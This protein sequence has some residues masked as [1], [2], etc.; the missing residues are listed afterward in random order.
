MT[1]ALQRD[2]AHTPPPADPVLAMGSNTS[3]VSVMHSCNGWKASLCD[4]AP[5]FRP[6]PPPPPTAGKPVAFAAPVSRRGVQGKLVSGDLEALPLEELYPFLSA[7]R[8]L[9]DPCEQHSECGSC[10]GDPLK[11]CGWGDG[12]ITRSDGSTCG[13][14]GNG[15]CGGES[16]LNKCNVA[17]RKVRQHCRRQAFLTG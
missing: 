6:P 12:V 9:G 8:W 15:C 10:I 4:F 17:F 2:G 3:D 7:A 11:T 14:D 5:A 16:G 1:I 13:S